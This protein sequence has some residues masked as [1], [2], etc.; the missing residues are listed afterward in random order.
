[1]TLY[2]RYHMGSWG[3]GILSLA[4]Y[5][6]RFYGHRKSC[7]EC[8][9]SIDPDPARSK[10]RPLPR[11]C[12][13]RLTLRHGICRVPSDILTYTAP[14]N[15]IESRSGQPLRSRSRPRPIWDTAHVW[16]SQHKKRFGRNWRRSPGNSSQFLFSAPT[17]Q[18]SFSLV[19]V[20]R[21]GMSE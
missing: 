4:A 3:G 20:L 2:P 11:L 5:L 17:C 15:W 16:V 21:E 10:P 6:V 14:A 8:D 19:S 18:P 1:M 9:E 7:A 13:G 12:Q